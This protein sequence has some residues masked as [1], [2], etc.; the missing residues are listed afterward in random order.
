MAAPEVVSF[1]T[2]FFR[3][4]VTSEAETLVSGKAGCFLAMDE[5][6]KSNLFGV[7]FFFKL[8]DPE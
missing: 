5:D 4:A 2:N 6:Q 1:E 7:T 3:I 8:K